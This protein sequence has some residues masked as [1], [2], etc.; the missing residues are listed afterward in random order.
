VVSQTL[1]LL[2]VAA[3]ILIALVPMLADVEVGQFR[4]AMVVMVWKLASPFWTD[5]PP[6]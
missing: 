2:Q 5:A 3:L 1:V 6:R 4:V